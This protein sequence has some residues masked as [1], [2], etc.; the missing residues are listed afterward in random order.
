MKIITVVGGKTENVRYIL[1][2]GQKKNK[3][4]T[5]LRPDPSLEMW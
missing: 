2:Y 1:E 5:K 3:N 4:K